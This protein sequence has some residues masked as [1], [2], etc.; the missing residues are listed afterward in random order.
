M[1]GSRKTQSDV[2]LFV[3][4]AAV[5]AAPLIVLFLST[6]FPGSSER[7]IDKIIQK[8]GLIGGILALIGT[9]V[10]GYWAFQAQSEN[11]ENLVRAENLRRNNSYAR[12]IRKQIIFLGRLLMMIKSDLSTYVMYQSEHSDLEIR[13]STLVA[14]L[15][16]Q[17]QPE[18]DS[19]LPDV[20]EYEINACHGC[21]LGAA[22]MLQQLYIQHNL[23]RQKDFGG[24]PFLAFD[25]DR[26]KELTAGADLKM[27]FIRRFYSQIRHHEESDLPTIKFP[28]E[29]IDKIAAT[30][31][32]T[33]KDLI[34]RLEQRSAQAAS[35]IDAG[36][37]S[38]WADILSSGIR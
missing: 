9:L 34:A 30:Y 17:K 7:V 12:D 20:I 2:F 19:I 27:F 36:H 25:I 18:F 38:E 21:I 22:N 33:G 31:R 35:N 37:G 13:E 23:V 14:R 1:R 10:A 32:W 28:P 16:E 3:A 11:T 6:S 29:E 5:T 24:G 26:V 4:C 15:N 8:D